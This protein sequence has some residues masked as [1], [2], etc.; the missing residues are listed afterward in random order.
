MRELASS[1]NGQ[2]WF[3]TLV[4]CKLKYSIIK[5]SKH[6]SQTARNGC[7]GTQCVQRTI[8]NNYN[9]DLAPLHALPAYD[10]HS[11]VIIKSLQLLQGQ[12]TSKRENTSSICWLESQS[13]CPKWGRGWRS[14]SKWASRYWWGTWGLLFNRSRGNFMGRCQGTFDLGT[15]YEAVN[16]SSSTFLALAQLISTFSMMYM[17]MWYM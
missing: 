10:I 11:F 7:K 5:Q 8:N 4:I 3:S 1:V 14:E 12:R 16:L 2:N 15:Q 9:V 6:H 17:C 13:I